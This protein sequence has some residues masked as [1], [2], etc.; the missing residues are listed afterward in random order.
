M[1]RRLKSQKLS[2][3]AIFASPWKRA[4]Q[5]ADLL[6]QHTGRRGTPV[7]LGA[8]AVT[9]A[10][11]PIARAIGEREANEVV[12]LVGHEPWIGE[13]ASL[14]LTGKRETL[15][16]DFPKGGVLGLEAEEFRTGAARL[17]FFLR[18]KQARHDD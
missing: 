11:S 10:V 7:E 6:F 17:R 16:I 4:W 2:P 15:S 9:P 3:G 12:A 1:A 14:L 8:L 5:S 13:L 18:P